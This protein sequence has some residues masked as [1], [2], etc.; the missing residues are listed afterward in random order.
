MQLLLER[1]IFFVQPVFHLNEVLFQVKICGAERHIRNRKKTA[2][3]CVRPEKFNSVPEFESTEDRLSINEG[4]IKKSRTVG[5]F[6]TPLGVRNLPFPAS[7]VILPSLVQLL[8][9]FL[10]FRSSLNIFGSSHPSVVFQSSLLSFTLL[11]E[12]AR[13]LIKPTLRRSWREPPVSEN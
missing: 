10:I 11:I 13:S 12:G 8:F 4:R 3:E 1:S 7:L 6:F 5:L 9:F 2:V